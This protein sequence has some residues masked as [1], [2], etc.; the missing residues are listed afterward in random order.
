MRI[1]IVGGTG[2]LGRHVVSQFADRGHEV[3]VL[4]RSSPDF[5]VDI[6]SGEGLARALDG[7]AVVVDA[8]NAA[9]AK[10]AA[11]VLGEG[12]RRLL[13]AGQAAGVSH[14]VCVS[15]VGCERFS[16]GYYRVKTEQEHI[17]ERGP[18]PWTIVKATQFHEL[19]AATLAAAGRWR[20]AAHPAD[21]AAD[22]RSCRGCGRAG[23][24]SRGPAA[25][26]PPPRRRPGA[27]HGPGTG[28]HLAVG[29]RPGCADGAGPG[30]GQ[31]RPGAAGRRA[32]HRSP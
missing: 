22:H 27:D 8:S 16:M 26:G 3:R 2:T 10:R 18:V 24:R 19:A 13:T 5:P 20:G 31:A 6:I 21:A 23:G 29:H 12:S 11:L 17:V 15:I 14:H 25:C 32:D 30:A 9:S 7:C 1:A 28:S 4:S